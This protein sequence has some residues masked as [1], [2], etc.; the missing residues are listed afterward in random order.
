MRNAAQPL[1]QQPMS[2]QQLNESI[3]RTRAIMQGMK[4]LGNQEVV[5][6]NLLQQYPQLGFLSNALKNGNSLEDIAKQMASMKG[7]DI[8]EILQGLNV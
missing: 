1:P 5:I 8:N 4:N 7:Y 6:A 3:E 2:Q